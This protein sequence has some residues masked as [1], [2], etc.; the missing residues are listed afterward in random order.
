MA[1]PR[2]A[3]A[4][5]KGVR[6]VLIAFRPWSEAAASEYMNTFTAL[7]AEPAMQGA[8]TAALPY[9]ICLGFQL[10]PNEN[11][12]DFFLDI[13]SGCVAC[14]ANP[15]F[16]IEVRC[17]ARVCLW[18]IEGYSCTHKNKPDALGCSL[19]LGC[20]SRLLSTTAQDLP[21]YMR[22]MA[23]QNLHS[24]WRDTGGRQ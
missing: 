10:P 1:A 2:A 14:H 15:D 7:I 18:H 21:F 19:V 3:E 4:H 13:V 17:C 24:V 11:P 9:F 20:C 8:S 23:K 12:A 16:Q 22:A 6:P 5:S